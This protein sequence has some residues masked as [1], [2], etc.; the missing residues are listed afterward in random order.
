MAKSVPAN[1]N[2]E[3]LKWSREEAGYSVEQAAEKIRITPEDLKEFESGDRR[4]TLLYN[5]D[6]P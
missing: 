4:I 6:N 3:V 1:I 5:L 2:P